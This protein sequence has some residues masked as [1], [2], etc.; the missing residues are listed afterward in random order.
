MLIFVFLVPITWTISFAMREGHIQ[1]ARIAGA[2]TVIIIPVMAFSVRNISRLPPFFEGV[3]FSET[4]LLVERYAQQ[5]FMNLSLLS[6]SPF[7]QTTFIIYALSSIGGL[8]S[9]LASLVMIFLY[10]AFAGS[11]SIYILRVFEKWVSKKTSFLPYVIVFALV[12]VSG[13]MATSVAYRYIAS[14]MFPLLFFSLMNSHLRK[15]FGSRLV[16][17]L[18]TI[19]ITL[20]DPVSSLLMI[21]LF[22]LYSILK[23]DYTV[24]LYAIIP[25][26]Y[27]LYSGELYISYLKAYANFAWS[28][29]SAFFQELLAGNFAQRT[30]PW[31]RTLS[32]A[33]EDSYLAS[34]SYISLLALALTIFTSS[35]IFWH[36]SKSEKGKREKDD[37]LVRAAIV[38]LFPILCV[39]LL[40]YIGVSV[41]AE[42]SFSDIRTIVIGYS[43]MLLL[44]SFASKTLL[45]KLAS[46]RLFLIV[47]IVLLVF[48]SFRVIF[49]DFPKS[50]QDPI[51]VVEDARV[52]LREMGYAGVFLFSYY[53]SGSVLY[54]YKAGYVDMSLLVKA[55]DK[56]SM[57]SL[58]TTDFRATFLV[59]DING[60]KY[61][62][63]YVPQNIY[64]QAYETGSNEDLIYNNGAIAIFKR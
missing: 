40:T 36:K 30:L 19:G 44:F 60:L 12:S 15:Q 45:S 7:F 23:R 3:E 33:P 11:I 38:Y 62:S 26:S 49:Q 52:D 1:D 35:I 17:L 21:P 56:A 29:V 59:L 27:L 2:I 53:R 5:G 57:L 46:H 43:A 54:D 48:S 20:G 16:F 28:G 63:S 13:L 4:R 55:P 41:Q 14:L 47:V 22:V 34:V 51:L 50:Y 39:V 58:S 64:A 32:I 37:A 42:V 25:A 31:Q 24:S 18:L 10:L 9:P 6:H 61:P 8:P